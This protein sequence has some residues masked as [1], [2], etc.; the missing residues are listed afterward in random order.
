MGVQIPLGAP[1]FYRIYLVVVKLLIFTY[2]PTGLG[3]LRVTDA[4]AEARPKESIFILLG[5]MDKFITGIHRWTSINPFGKFLFLKSQYGIFEDIFTN[6]YRMILVG[7]AGRIYKKLKDLIIKYETN[8]E[9]VL[10]IATHFGMAH[11]IGAIKDKL[12]KE[13]GKTVRLIVQVTDDTSQHIWVVRGADMT[14]VPSRFTK[15]ELAEYA[16]EKKI[17]FCGE[18]VP[19]PLSELL[20][21]KLPKGKGRHKVFSEKAGPINV[22]IPISGAAVG[23]T[24]FINVIKE[25]RKQSDRFRF[26]VLVKKTPFTEMFI[27]SLAR[28]TQVNLF[29]GKNDIQMIE[30]Y[31]L[32]YQNN[33]IHLEITKPSEQSFKAI[34]YPS[35]VG[36]SILLFTSPVGRQE[37]DNIKFLERHGLMPMTGMPNTPRAIRIPDNPKVAA[38]FIKWGVDEGLF[39]R[40][41]APSFVFPKKILDSG[42]VGPDGAK[43]FWKKVEN[44]FWK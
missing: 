35:S 33:M 2:A 44:K 5:S 6:V 14:F 22:A 34:L 17:D 20:T 8:E 41:T 40:M 31:E 19:Y 24:F 37:I 9:E 10:I 26:F 11:Q 23:L 13:T 18:V 3:H 30:S 43:L 39:S 1:S 15:E 16:K 27:R 28:M 7:T 4:V 29:V 25:L 42:E 21:K 32:I 12:A 36:G 38:Q